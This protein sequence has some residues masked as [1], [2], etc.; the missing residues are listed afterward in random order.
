MKYEI[1]ER[2]AQDILNYLANQPYKDV[3]RIISEI[4]KLKPMEERKS[5]HL[6]S[7]K[8]ECNG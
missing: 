4:S 3:V 8:G 1:E 2:L 5:E 7:Q 6:I